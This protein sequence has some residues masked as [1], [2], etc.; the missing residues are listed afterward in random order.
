MQNFEIVEIELIYEEETKEL[1]LEGLKERFDIWEP[2]PE[3]ILNPDLKDMNKYYKQDGYKF[4][5]GLF[6]GEVVCAG[7]LQEIN[8]QCAELGRVTVK[9]EYRKNG[10]GK[11]MVEE[12][13]KEAIRMG[14]KKLMLY[15]GEDW[16]S[17]ISLYETLNY[18]QNEYI[19]KDYGNLL[20]M[21]KN[22]TSDK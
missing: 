2:D 18:F 17:A 3:F 4:L 14:Y 21:T 8:E 22:L 15:T 1:I 19:K 5:V 9:T 7:G 6:N 16:Y 13:E 20:K 11:R 12:L 10:L